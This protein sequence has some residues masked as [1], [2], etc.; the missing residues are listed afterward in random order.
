MRC[1]ARL[2]FQRLYL[3]MTVV[4]TPLKAL[5][6]PRDLGCMRHGLTNVSMCTV[7]PVFTQKSI[8]IVRRAIERGCNSEGFPKWRITSSFRTDVLGP[9]FNEINRR[10]V[11]GLSP[12]GGL[13]QI[14][15]SCQANSRVRTLT[16]SGFL[17]LSCGNRVSHLRRMCLSP[18]RLLRFL[19]SAIVSE[20]QGF[21]E[22]RNLL[23]SLLDRQ[24]K[25]KTPTLIPLPLLYTSWPHGLI[26]T[27]FPQETPF[28]LEHS[29]TGKH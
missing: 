2:K 28:K 26:S 11:L 1:A 9:G 29:D 22:R 15:P 20:G 10:G 25:P 14:F 16:S 13:I 19:A 27:C 12:R 6:V 17:F 8:Q 7:E 4:D 23:P 18:L 3:R 21:P 5:T 24:D